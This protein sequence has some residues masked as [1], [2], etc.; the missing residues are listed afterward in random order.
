MKFLQ[1]N[2]MLVHTPTLVMWNREQPLPKTVKEVLRGKAA[3]WERIVE[4]LR[5]AQDGTLED[6]QADMNISLEEAGAWN[7][8]NLMEDEYL[9]LMNPSVI[10]DPGWGIAPQIFMDKL[11]ETEITPEVWM[12]AD[13]P[14]AKNENLAWELS[15]DLLD[16]LYLPREY[17]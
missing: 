7:R 5:E 1:P 9:N 13:D 12:T 11:N 4:I 2:E 8:I 10:T 3:L 16:P 15:D 17:R 14:E 6:L